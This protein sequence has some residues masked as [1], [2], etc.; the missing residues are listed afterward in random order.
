MRMWVNSYRAIIIQ[1]VAILYAEQREREMQKEGYYERGGKEI[2]QGFSSSL[3]TSTN[4]CV[5]GHP[6]N[7]KSC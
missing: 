5:Y 3:R 6:A 7:K 1:Q 4:I 2:S